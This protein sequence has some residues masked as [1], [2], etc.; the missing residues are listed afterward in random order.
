MVA[1]R[2]RGSFPV[3]RSRRTRALTAR[4]V[5]LSLV[6]LASAF[7][8]VPATASRD[9]PV[10]R[11]DEGHHTR[12]G[13]VTAGERL[14]GRGS[15]SARLDIP[16]G[17]R[18]VEADLSWTGTGAHCGTGAGWLFS[19]GQQAPSVVLGSTRVSPQSVVEGTG[20]RPSSARAD[21]FD[22]LARL[23]G[24]HG[25]TVVVGGPSCV[26]GWSLHVVWT[27]EVPDPEISAAGRIDRGAAHPGDVVS[28][29]VVVTNTGG[30][31][32]HDVLAEFDIGSG[33]RK[34]LGTLA[35]GAAVAVACAGAA[36]E[37]D[38]SVTA[39]VRGTSA[40]GR[41]VTARTADVVR[42]LRPALELAVAREH[43]MVLEG[44]DA[45]HE[46]AL[47]NSGNTELS[48][49]AL[50]GDG[51]RCDPLPATMG[52]GERRQV[53]CAVRAG[54]GDVV[55]NL[56]ASGRDALGAMAVDSSSVTTKGVRP[57]IALEVSEAGTGTD[58][59][60]RAEVDVRVRNTSPIPLDH[61]V[62]GGEPADCREDI[63]WLDAGESSEY[64]CRVAR[65]TAVALSVS[66]R[67]V[68][69]GVVADVSHTVRT[70]TV[71]H[72]TY[73]VNPGRAGRPAA[74]LAQRERERAGGGG[75]PLE[76]P[77]R[78]AGF[79]GILGALVMMVSVGALS[80][81]S[82]AKR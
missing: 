60:G 17:A 43:G 42:V 61:V 55:S 31:E 29:D 13:S 58:R 57:S 33:C 73:A 82:R 68:I 66:G 76:S 54:S 26:E 9:V 41:T 39:R 8:V 6:L 10:R 11:L 12:T 34:P 23:V 18:I 14:G 22:E 69:D 1:F 38:A 70:T 15:S 36:G 7:M 19:T 28:H 5:R 75:G 32:L 79:I 63:G 71:L 67:P 65:G 35:P 81:A 53:R 48:G 45:V 20:G 40:D 52:P 25:V 80:T 44:D 27:I 56:T 46:L 59:D 3:I 49:L 77:E 37:R 30:T 78:T 51:A 2:I 24:D 72:V 64:R 62:V 4:G 74:A 16:A 47:R 50:T 21:V